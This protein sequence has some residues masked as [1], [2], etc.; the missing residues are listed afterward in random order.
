VLRLAYWLLTFLF[1]WTILLVALLG[2]ARLWLPMVNDY[3]GILE[4]ELSRFVGNQINIGQMRV[5]NDGDDLLWVLENLQLTEPS[6]QSPIQIRQLVLTVD[7]RESLRTLSLQP[8]EIKLEGVEFILRQQAHELPDIQGLTFPLPG[9]KNTVLNIERQSPLRISINSGFVHWLDAANHRSLTLSDLQFIGE[10]LPNEIT[11]QAD[12][13][14]PPAIGETLGVDAVLHQAPASAGK[15]QWEG[16]LHTRT[17]IF[18]LA[19]LPSPLLKSYGVTAGGLIL[20]AT[21]S[22][23]SGK[24]LR[25]SGE[26]EVTHLSS[27][28]NAD[29]PALQ[30][31]N[32]TFAA[33]N[34]GGK[35]KVNIS[36]SSLEY[37]QWFE[38]PLRVDALD[39]DLN[40]TVQPEGWHW[41]LAQLTAKNPDIT[42]QGSGK[43]DLPHQ[44]PPNL[45]LALTFATQRTVDNVRDYIPALL[46][47]HTER[48]L[49]TAIVQGYV[50]KGEFVL[51]GNPADFPFQHTA[52]V[53]DIRFAIEKGVLAYLPEWPKAEAVNGELHFHNAD[54]NA[55]VHSATIMDLDVRGGS[56]AIPNM[57][58]KDNHLLL[59]LQTQ[60]DL[61]AH[62]N[63]LRDA[64]IGHSLRD[65]MQVA[66]FAGDSDLHLKLDVPLQETTLAAQGVAVDGLVGLHDNRFAI[67]DYGQ[68]FT[69]LNGKVHFDQHGVNVENATGEYRQQPLKLSAKTDQA[70]GIIRV[71]LQ[72]QQSPSVFL[73]ESLASLKP[74]LRGKTTVATSLELPAFNA[75]PDK[76]LRSLHI[77]SRSE[78]AGVAIDLPP[79]FAKTA[80]ATRPLQVDVDLPFDANQ[81]WQMDVDMGKYLGVTARLPHQGKQPTAIG[82][83]VGGAAAILPERGMRVEGELAELDLLA[84]HGFGAAMSG[85]KPD[86]AAPP[87]VIAN[88]GVA[89]L[90]LGAQALGKA[91]I[92]VEQGDI[93]KAHVRAERLQAMLH[94]PRK[95]LAAGRVNLDFNHVDLDKLSASLPKRAGSKAS[96]LSPADFPSLR[97]TCRE[98]QKGDFPIEQLTLNLNKVRD[99]LQIDAFELRNPQLTLA[100]GQGRWYRTAAG[101]SQTELT[102]TARMP[103]PGKL[104]AKPGSEASLQE[105]ALQATAKLHWEGAPFSFAL[106]KVQGDIQAHFGKGSLSDVDPGLGRLLGLLDAQRLPE[107]LTLDFRDMTTKG[108]AFD[109]ITGN[110]HLDQGILTTQDTIIEAAALNAG[111]KGSLNLTRK[112]LDQ[113][114][115][116]I[117]NLRSTLPV[118]GV[119]VG[120]I[121]GGAAMLL[122]NSLT[123]KTAAEQLKTAGGLRYR[124]TGAWEKPEIVDLKLPFKK[125][126]VDVLLH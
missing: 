76:A 104:L 93:L 37:P 23:V 33:N 4:S 34:A 115:T 81:P 92:T 94:L 102:A 87:S 111:I 67:P 64:P 11:L 118:V 70:R 82:V 80:E 48:W 119:A 112:T 3:K 98:C 75:P 117:P 78:L 74:Y 105:G 52:G 9:Q 95:K 97:V 108:V 14:F 61:Q 1:H 51:R 123:E 86:A 30:G 40:W 29:V 26:G 42:L 13:L 54:M 72:Q 38:K 110:F 32:A 5:D 103:E 36:D 39:A 57:L 124:V 20:D 50:P 66:T 101:A 25:V 28:G 83:S 122:L 44:Q 89:N 113:T 46:P 85:G 106:P 55:T 22:A 10:I 62:M 35:V 73:P 7:W 100:A 96:S 18:N 60:G 69:Q 71:D 53:F 88:L 2:L 59:D 63:Y 6:G 49:K 17:Q 114:L 121:G 21:I 91:S 58:A 19:A 27:T 125:T 43:L 8:A 77:Q 107:R 126:D 41:Q 116:V 47:D 31:V 79:P 45:D 56:V 16:D 24:P 84:W 15:P 90:L 99:D 109:A 68:L 65:F 12:A 120:G